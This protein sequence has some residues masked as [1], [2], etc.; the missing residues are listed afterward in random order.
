MRRRKNI[1][2]I[3]KKFDIDVNPGRDRAIFDELQKAQSESRQTAAL[4]PNISRFLVNSRV[5]HTAVAAAIV[6]VLSLF[7]F[8]V[9]ESDQ[10]QR[11]QSDRLVAA[12]AS[13]TPSELVSVVSLNIVF[14]DG[15]MKAVER[16]FEQAEKKVFPTLRESIVIDQ[17]ISE[18]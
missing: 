9:N 10:Q 5:V 1:E 13:K 11:R 14:R 3:I 15:D 18:L 17:L 16:Q 4:R 12:A 7:W 8:A 6:I 2:K